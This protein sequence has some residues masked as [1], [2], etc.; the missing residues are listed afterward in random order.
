MSKYL[1]PGRK[2]LCV[3][4]LNAK[5]SLQ[6]RLTFNLVAYCTCVRAAYW[7]DN[8]SSHASANPPELQVQPCSKPP[9][10]KLAGKLLPVRLFFVGKAGCVTQRLFLKMKRTA[11][12]WPH[13]CVAPRSRVQLLALAQ[14]I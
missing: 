6:A 3:W 7:P 5:W 10:G 13:D 9:V 4:A 12:A 1:V 11:N 8:S 2:Q 14:P